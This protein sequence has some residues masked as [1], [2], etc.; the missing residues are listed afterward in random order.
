MTTKQNLLYHKSKKEAT[1]FRRYI[2]EKTF[3]FSWELSKDFC[4]AKRGR[5][6][7]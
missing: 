2:E 1:V 6:D 7:D 5:H 4:F 3:D